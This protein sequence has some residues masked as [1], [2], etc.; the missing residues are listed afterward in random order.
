VEG[1]PNIKGLTAKAGAPASVTVSNK[2]IEGG[3][4]LDII[5]DCFLCKNLPDVFILKWGEISLGKL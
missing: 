2:F 1:F 3:G 4:T 5:H